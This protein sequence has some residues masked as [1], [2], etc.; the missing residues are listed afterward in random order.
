MIKYYPI[1]DSILSLWHKVMNSKLKH[2]LLSIGICVLFAMMGGLLV[3]DALEGWFK[4]LRHPWYSLPLWGWYMIGG[5]Y[6]L[7]AIV[8]LYKLLNKPS[9]PKRKKAIGL[10]IIM[11][12]GNE[13]W[14]YLFF[15]LES[16]LAGFLGLIPF[17][18]VVIVLFFTLFRYERNA[19]WI[20]FPYLLW[21]GYDLIWTYS[22]WQ[23][24]H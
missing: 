16:T 7:I 10:T 6:Y 15:G 2:L 1:V 3:G 5:L 12:A 4:A 14:N 18:A 24:N 11:I 17:T 21:L 9:S 13:Y 23:L 22:L 8:I 19:S 20:L